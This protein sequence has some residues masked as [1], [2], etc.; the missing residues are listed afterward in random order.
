MRI[1]I[2]GASGMLGSDVCR[3]ASEAGL[4]VVAFDR[5]ALDVADADQ[6]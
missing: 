3:T 1:L 5:S 4:D 2:T 6:V